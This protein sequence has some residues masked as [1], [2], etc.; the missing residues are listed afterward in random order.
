MKRFVPTLLSCIAF[1][2]FALQWSQPVRFEPLGAD[3]ARFVARG[4]HYGFEISGSSAEVSAG[5][6]TVLLKFAGAAAPKL[7]GIGRLRST[8]NILRGADS[9]QWR[10]GI[11][12]FHRVVA[13]EI[14][15]GIDVVYYGAAGELEYDLVLKPGADP[16][17]IR[18]QVT[19]VDPKL[20]AEGNLI[21][22]L[23]HKRPVTYQLAE[24]GTR[25]AVA[26]RFRRNADGTFGFALSGYNRN[27][28]LVIDP[29]L[30]LSDYLSG[31]NQD[32]AVAVGHDR[33]GFVYVAGNTLSSDLPVT[34]DTSFKATNSGGRICLWRKSIRTL[35]RSST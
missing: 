2:C 22:G 29:Q 10:R 14:Y 5:G 4:L 18:L 31:S 13:H 35:H 32:I 6:K 30:T 19:G 25:K 8:T 7:E 15:P 23:V 21:A 27:R 34:S 33:Q 3:Q 16:S 9:R 26:S 12:N 17:G 20:D 24:D 1:P 11:P 28:D